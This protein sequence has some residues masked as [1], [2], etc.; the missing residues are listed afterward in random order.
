[1]VVYSLGKYL[2]KP[3][4]RNSAH[5]PGKNKACLEFHFIFNKIIIKIFVFLDTEGQ[6]RT[7]AISF[8]EKNY[9]YDEKVEN[10]I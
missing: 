3:L 2:Q 5:F 9:M 8:I 6:P 7:K 1:M 4:C 10:F